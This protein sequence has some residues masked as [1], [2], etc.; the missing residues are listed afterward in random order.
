MVIDIVADYI[1]KTISYLRSHDYDRIEAKRHGAENWSL[2][3]NQVFEQTVVAQ[4]AVETNSWYVGANI[5]SK[6]HKTLL[7]F[8]GIPN[9]MNALN[10]E[11]DRGYPSHLL[12][13]PKEVSV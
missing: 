3:V 7:Y 11:V 5:K 8:G 6:L 12:S 10:Q 9:Y 1:G 4:T 13:T 2:Q